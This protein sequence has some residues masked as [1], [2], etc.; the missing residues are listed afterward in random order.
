VALPRSSVIDSPAAPEV[1]AHATEANA[2]AVKIMGLFV[3]NDF[4]KTVRMC[5]VGWKLHLPM[6]T[7]NDLLVNSR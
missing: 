7:N 6:S 3:M 2:K 4:V 5:V 1:D